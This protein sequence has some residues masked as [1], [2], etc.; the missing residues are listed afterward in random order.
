MD[1]HSN[2]SEGSSAINRRAG[3]SLVL[4]VNKCFF[5]TIQETS[6]LDKEKML[7]TLFSPPGNEPQLV[8]KSM[9]SHSK[10]EHAAQRQG[11]QAG[12]DIVI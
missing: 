5:Q 1:I 12:R 10:T 8:R 7:D 6:H 4:L 9:M 2:Y 11:K 3:G